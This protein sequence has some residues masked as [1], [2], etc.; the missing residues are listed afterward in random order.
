MDKTDLKEKLI[1]LG[2]SSGIFLPIR[3]I[4]AAFVSDHWLGSVGLVSA[5]GVLMVVLIKKNKLGKF[6]EIFERQMKK[7]IGGKTGKYVII[8]AV[9][10]SLYF[11]T[12]LYLMERGNAVYLHDKE[13]FYE[14][15]VNK[16]Q[17]TIQDI[18][19]ERLYGP[20]TNEVLNLNFIAGL[21]YALSISFAIMNDVTNGW[22]SHLIVVI[23]VE[24]IEVVGLL[25]FYRKTYGKKHV[26]LKES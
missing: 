25:F 20:D 15:I 9:L 7:T 22:L 11:G 4:F 5:F 14:A 1:V 13:I 17:F 10:F 8:F 18:P 19:K 12:S 21:D 6:G 23:F 26:I 2:V 24:Q 3:I 16:E